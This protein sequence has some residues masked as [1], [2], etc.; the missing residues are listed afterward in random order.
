[1]TDFVILGLDP[2]IHPGVLSTYFIALL[3]QD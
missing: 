1:M 2:R 3:G